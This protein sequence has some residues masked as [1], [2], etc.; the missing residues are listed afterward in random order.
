[1][2]PMFFSKNKWL[3]C[4]CT[5]AVC[6]LAQAESEQNWRWHSFVDLRL[7]AT[8]NEAS[9]FDNGTGKLR[10]G[11]DAKNKK[12]YLITLGELALLG[13][14]R[15]DWAWSGHFY[16]KADDEQQTLIDPVEVYLKYKPVPQ[17][18]WRSEIRAG[19]FFPE[20][21]QENVA[22]GWR[23][24]FTIT[25]SAINSWFGEEL[26]S[27]GLE[28]DTSY[29][30][31]SRTRLGFSGALIAAND[32][33]GTLLAWRGWSLHDRN[34]GYNDRMPLPA[35]PD[36]QD[37]GMF[38][39]QMNG[40]EPFKEIDNNVGYYLAVHGKQAKRWQWHLLYYDNNGDIKNP[41]E[42]GQYAWATR[43]VH[44]GGRYG[45]TP[46]LKIMT[47]LI[48]GNTKMGWTDWGAP[49]DNDFWAG[50]L[51]VS[52]RLKPH[53]ISLRFDR[54]AVVDKDKAPN[55]DN[56]ER[57]HAWTGSY[58]YRWNKKVTLAGEVI[59]T[60][61]KRAIRE[62]LGEPEKQHQWLGQIGLHYVL[63]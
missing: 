63:W 24:P 6:N 9:Q 45:I 28:A 23:S 12:Q 32:P 1:M 41:V 11:G 46:S 52:K 20:L 57:G 5:L 39:A 2:A 27:I 47:Q 60:E 10:Y 54:F 16:F 31:P 30:F 34:I 33:L 35:A 17:S 13:S 44:V 3:M 61:N 26:R 62:A 58:Q 53:R 37:G 21:S 40:V 38:A 18:R 15:F 22:P 19:M 48:K 25:P 59:Y 29:Q 56:N 4:L 43:F 49:V 8:D 50:Y 14:Y 42:D 36:L 51:L 55:D 7:V